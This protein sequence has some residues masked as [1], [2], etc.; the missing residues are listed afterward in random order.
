MSLLFTSLIFALLSGGWS[1]IQGNAAIRIL[2]W[3][4]VFSTMSLHITGSSFAMTRWLDR[5]ITQLR[6]QS[7]AFGIIAVLTGVSVFWISREWRAPTTEDLVNF[8]SVANYFVA[9]PDVGPLHYLLLPAKWLMQPL[10]AADL[11]SFLA[12]LG[13]AL[14]VFAA[15]YLWV[16]YSEASFEEGSIVKAKKRAERVAAMR[17]GNVR[18]GRSVPKARRTPFDVSSVPRVELAFFWKNLLSSAEYLRLRTALITALVILVGSQ[19]LAHSDYDILRTAIGSVALGIAVYALVFGPLIARQDLR[20]DLL[21]AD[22]LK[23]YPLRGWQIVL[24]EI[25]TPVAIVTVLLWLMLLTAALNFQPRGQWLTNEIRVWGAVGVA[26]LIPLLCAIQV[27]VLN[28]GVVL[29]PAW[30]QVGQSRGAGIDVLGQRIF[31]IAA[32]FITIGAALLPAAVAASAIYFSV[33]WV[34]DIPIAA[35][36]AAA[37]LLGILCFEIGLGVQWLGKRF[38]N[39]DLSAELRP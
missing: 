32:L 34:V 27:L 23:T 35:A 31:F 3:W 36:L 21:N 13:P 29:F 17:A 15:H 20:N 39:F 18:L 7:I 16:L 33:Q 8:S 30:M 6:R 11:R 12:A 38:E 2:G 24:G 19:W 37:T 10:L 1:F 9:M 14:L 25:L 28:A 4:I 5:G 22:I 26:L